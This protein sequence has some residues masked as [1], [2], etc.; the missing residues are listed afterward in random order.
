MTVSVIV[1]CHNCSAYLKTALDSVVAQHEPDWEVILW[2][3]ASDEPVESLVG[4]YND[5]R[6][7]YFYDREFVP[8]GEARNRA[9]RQASGEF[10]AF[11]DADD[12]WRPEKL[13]HQLALFR[14]SPRVGLVYSDAH[15]LYE[16]RVTK[17]VFANRLPPE[18]EVFGTLL[19]SYFLVMSSVMIRRQALDRLRTWFDPHFEIIEEYDLFLRIAVD[20]DLRCATG[21][22]TTW[23][24][25]EASTTMRKRRRISLE[26]RLL[27][28]QL[29]T[30]YPEL[31]ARHQEDEHKVKG[32]ILVSS[33]IN[34]YY[35]N[36]PK[37][38]RRLLL[39]SKRWSAKGIVV[40][41]ATFF[42]VGWTERMYRRLV[43]N[44][45]I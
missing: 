28:K 9:L 42:P 35:A 31:M 7:R 36:R 12:Y 3:N 5:S 43:G 33:A 18:G 40:F 2:D 23:R 8:L 24:W 39:S 21:P 4:K 1:N 22:L 27:L 29:R 16:R 30:A 34:A 44:P 11:L 10:I 14:S 41:F 15:I 19:S 38:S 6:I 17:R 25:H 13:T 26:K 20:W 37:T 45:L 32:K